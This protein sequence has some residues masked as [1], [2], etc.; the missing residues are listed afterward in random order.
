VTLHKDPE[1]RISQLHRDGS[2]KSSRRSL[3]TGSKVLN[4]VL[5]RGELCT[6]RGGQV[7]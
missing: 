2:V 5:R 3:F 4:F 1:K 7:F 6:K